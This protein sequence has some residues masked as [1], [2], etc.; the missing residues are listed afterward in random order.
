M[1]Y[2]ICHKCF[3]RIDTCLQPSV[4][5]EK[6]QVAGGIFYSI[7]HKETLHNYF[8]LG[9]NTLAHTINTVHDGKVWWII[10]ENTT[11][12]P[13][14]DWLYFLWGSIK[15]RTAESFSSMHGS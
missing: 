8:I 4:S 15:H 13:H 5:T 12:I 9:E 11:P 1:E 2:P 7:Y 14:N 6:A 3:L 10:D